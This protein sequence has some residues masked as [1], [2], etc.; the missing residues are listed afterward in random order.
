M[1]RIHPAQA[2][3]GDSS[4]SMKVLVL[5]LKIIACVFIFIA[6]VA[7]GSDFLPV[8]GISFGGHGSENGEHQFFKIV[9]TNGANPIFLGVIFLLAAVTLFV[10]AGLLNKYLARS[11][12]T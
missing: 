12:S 1:W 2:K 7:F 11:S 5:S 4:E 6:L 9:P 10:A 8:D 3:R